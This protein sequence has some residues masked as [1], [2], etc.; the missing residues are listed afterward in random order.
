[1]QPQGPPPQMGPRPPSLAPGLQA[2]PQIPPELLALL[3]AG[4][5]GSPPPGGAMPPTPTGLE[6]SPPPPQPGQY[7]DLLSL[8]KSGDPRAMMAMSE[9]LQMEDSGEPDEMQSPLAMAMRGGMGSGAS[10]LGGMMGGNIPV[11]QGGGY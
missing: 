5:G 8:L 11:S 4:P 6:M 2:P 9:L 3:Q 10:G 1:M 7:G